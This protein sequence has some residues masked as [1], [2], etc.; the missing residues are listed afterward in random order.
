M[1]PRALCAMCAPNSLPKKST[2]I[3]C[4]TCAKQSATDCP[5]GPP[6]SPSCRHTVDRPEAQVFLLPLR[7]IADPDLGRA[8]DV[9]LTLPTENLLNE[10]NHLFRLRRDNPGSHCVPVVWQKMF[11]GRRLSFPNLS[12]FTLIFRS[13]H[14]SRLTEK[15]FDRR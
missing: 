7:R 5:M 4:I 2:R 10:T 3:T 1:T 13:L 6:P 14:R 11:H 9:E 8:V 15:V 12:E